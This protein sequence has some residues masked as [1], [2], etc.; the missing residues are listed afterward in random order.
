MEKILEQIGQIG[1]VPVIAIKDSDKAVPLAGALAEGGLPCAE[2]TFRTAEGEESIRRISAQRPDVLVG[3]GTVLTT[4]QVDRAIGAGARFI[5]SPG[6]NPKVVDYCIRQ[7]IPVT[8]GCSTPTDMEQAIERELEVVKFFP[9]EQSGGLSYIK[10][11]QHLAV[12]CALCPPA[13]L[14]RPI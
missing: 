2:V 8:P 11:L 14:V 4:E 13:V 12:C 7:G 3:A 10:P 5:V 6:F 1:V 9:V